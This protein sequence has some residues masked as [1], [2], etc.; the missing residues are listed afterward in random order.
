VAVVES[1]TPDRFVREPERAAA[2]DV[3]L[4]GEALLNRIERQAAELGVVRAR[5][6]TVVGRLEA[7]RSRTQQLV[8]ALETETEARAS[9]EAALAEATRERDAL[10]AELA[11]TRAVLED[12]ATE[13]DAAN[14]Q[15]TTLEE[16]MNLAWVQLKEAE[17]ETERARRRGLRKLY[18]GET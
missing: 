15:T 10:A 11:E 8:R 17:A 1:V 13:L 6:D 3:V 12:T 18:R 7:E 4:A 9:L 5:L 14:V 16:R 2:A